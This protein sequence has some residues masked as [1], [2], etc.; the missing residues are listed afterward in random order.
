MARQRSKSVSIIGLGRVG[1]ALAVALS[2]AG[3][4]LVNFVTRR[5]SE[6]R[7]KLAAL[8]LAVPVLNPTNLAQLDADLIVIA[9]PDDQ[10]TDVARSL[11]EL[12]TNSRRNR[13]ALH[14]SGALSSSVLS[15]LRSKGWKTGSL[16]PLISVRELKGRE[17]IFRGA[18]WCIEGDASAIKLAGRLVR[19]LD[20]RSFTVSTKQKPLYHASAVM[21]AGNLVALLSVA[22]GLLHECGIEEKLGRQILEPLARSALQNFSH[23]P[24][25]ALTGPFARGDLATVSLHLEALSTPHM[26]KARELYSL[27]GARSIELAEAMGLD[28]EKALALQEL[29]KP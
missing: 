12:P 27:L 23:D 6:A 25:H 29:L 1:T 2:D 21:A 11:A 24:G 28:H 5:P 18:F 19:D 8:K 22:T 10:I 4:S 26:H 7:R 17:N 20:G 15:P 16:H 14:T 3:Y 13:V 9:T